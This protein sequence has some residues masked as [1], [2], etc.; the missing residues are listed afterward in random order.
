MY[1]VVCTIQGQVRYTIF[2]SAKYEVNNIDRERSIP[3]SVAE[4]QKVLQEIVKKG[5]SL[6]SKKSPLNL[7]NTQSVHVYIYV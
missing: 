5:V 1:I 6:L 7:I 2:D 4:R 3:V